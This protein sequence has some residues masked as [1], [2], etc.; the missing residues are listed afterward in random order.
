MS[1]TNKEFTLK[2]AQNAVLSRDFVLASRL[3]KTILKEEPNNIDVL[4]QLGST[5]VRSGDDEKALEVY[6]RIVQIDNMN[7]N[8]LKFIFIPLLLMPG[9]Q[10]VR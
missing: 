3:F 4:S 1:D 7:F 9:R 10:Y 6:K 8:A 2:R 5:Y